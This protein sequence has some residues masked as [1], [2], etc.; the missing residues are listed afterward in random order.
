MPEMDGFELTRIIRSE[1]TAR[2]PIVALT[3]DALPGTGQ[4]CLDAGMD[5]Y[6][7]KP[8]D[9]AALVETLER[10]LPQASV[11]RLCAEVAEFGAAIPEID[12]KILD[13]ARLLEA[14]GA[15]DAEARGFLDEF[16]AD[17]PRLVEAITAALATPDSDAAR[18]AAHALKGAARSAGAMRLGQIASDVQDCLDGGDVETAGILAELLPPTHAELLDATASLRAA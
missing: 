7:T 3:A 1:E 9:S 8:I 4:Q 16:L 10:L 5:G 15:W 13:L 14:F 17:V 11:L 2:R 12:P 18:A 6:L